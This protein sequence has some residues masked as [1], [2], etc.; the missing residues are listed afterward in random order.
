MVHINS[1][2][3]RISFELIFGVFLL[4]LTA[5]TISF[6]VTI[7]L[8]EKKHIESE[9]FN[10]QKIFY[11]LKNNPVDLINT[12]FPLPS[13]TTIAI[14]NL[15]KELVKGINIWNTSK[16][17]PIKLVI[18]YGKDFFYPSVLMYDV[19]PSKDQ[20]YILVIRRDFDIEKKFLKDTIILFTPFAL[21]CLITLTGFS[22]II[23]RKRILVPL[24][25]LQLSYQNID[26]PSS[27]TKLNPVNIKEWDNLFSQFNKMMDR[28]KEYEY[29]LQKRIEELK[30]ANIKIKNTQDEI[31]FSEKMATVGRLSAGLAHEIGNPL[32]SIIGYLSYLISDSKDENIKEILKIIMKETERINNIIRDLLNF[33]RQE[34]KEYEYANPLEIIEETLKLLIP[35]KDF[36]KI[37]IIKSFKAES[38]VFFSKES[39][40]Q[41]ILNLLLNAIDVT[42]PQGTI[43][44]KTYVE[45]NYYCIEIEDEGGG[46]PDEIKDKI[47][48]PFFT[49]KPS[50]KG[51]GLGLSVALTLV[52]RYNGKLTFINRDK[53]ASFI[54][55]LKTMVEKNG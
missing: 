41:V 24:K 29:N 26:N 42:P 40:K 9:V 27:M 13:G 48:E 39:L 31:I 37:N 20:N 8:W 45:N 17:I 14:Y 38:L 28:L 11:D 44:I 49:T 53:G 54:I 47:F 34:K 21:I 10:L 52:E 15:K 23:Y 12:T 19:V 25:I 35:Q 46:I 30:E 6:F 36:S 5:I 2:R 3:G 18:E 50:G 33:A 55:K 22:Y 1:M 4:S 51:T 32:T 43:F 16:N 7:R